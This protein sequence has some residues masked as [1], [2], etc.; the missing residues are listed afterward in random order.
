VDLSHWIERH[1]RFAPRAPA[2]RFE[3]GEITYE[4]LARRVAA[5]ASALHALG[6]QRG[7]AVAFLGLN[8]PAAPGAS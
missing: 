7:D 2:V 5:A 1:A 6:V 3:G 8:N 4:E